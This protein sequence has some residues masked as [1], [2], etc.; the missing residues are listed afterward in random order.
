[1]AK[2]LDIQTANR[3]Y[4]F[5]REPEPDSDGTRLC[6]LYKG[7]EVIDGEDITKNAVFLTRPNPQTA[8]P[9]ARV[10][11]ENRMAA[12]DELK[13][14]GEV[15]DGL[16]TV[17]WQGTIETHGGVGIISEGVGDYDLSDVVKLAV[18]ERGEERTIRARELLPVQ[19]AVGIY[20][21][22]LDIVQKINSEKTD[23]KGQIVRKGII[24]CDIIPQNIRL[25]SDLTK[26]Y[27]IDFGIAREHGGQLTGFFN[28]TPYIEEYC[29][30]EVEVDDG[31][32]NRVRKQA[33]Y[34]GS[35]N[36]FFNEDYRPNGIEKVENAHEGIDV[37][38]TTNILYLM[39]MGKVYKGTIELPAD[40]PNRDVFE[41]VFAAG[42]NLQPTFI[43][44]YKEVKDALGVLKERIASASE[45]H[46]LYERKIALR[47]RPVGMGMEYATL[48]DVIIEAKAASEQ[49]ILA[50]AW[51][52]YLAR[53]EQEYAA[54]EPVWEEII[55]QYKEEAGDG[56]KQLEIRSG[57]RSL[58]GKYEEQMRMLKEGQTLVQGKTPLE[59]RIDKRIGQIEKLNQ[60]YF[61][62]EAVCVAEEGKLEK[63]NHDLV[64]QIRKGAHEAHR[65][66]EAYNNPPPLVSIAA[67]QTA[68]R[69]GEDAKRQ[70]DHF[71]EGYDAYVAKLKDK[72]QEVGSED[73]E[74]REALASRLERLIKKAENM[75]TAVN[76]CF[77]K[78]LPHEEQRKAIEETNDTFKRGIE[79]CSAVQQVGWEFAEFEEGYS[80][81]TKGLYQ[82]AERLESEIRKAWKLVLHAESLVRMNPDRTAVQVLGAAADNLEN[83]KKVLV[84]FNQEYNAHRQKLADQQV[85]VL[86]KGEAGEY[87][88]PQIDELQK[89]VHGIEEKVGYVP[90]L[91]L[92]DQIGIITKTYTRL[93]REKR[94]YELELEK[95]EQEQLFEE[96]ITRKKLIADAATAQKKLVGRYKT[97]RKEFRD[98][99]YHTD[100]LPQEVKRVVDAA[101]ERTRKFREA[102]D[103]TIANLEAHIGHAEELSVLVREKPFGDYDA[104]KVGDVVKGRP[105]YVNFLAR[106]DAFKQDVSKESDPNARYY[107]AVAQGMILLG[108]DWLEEAAQKQRGIRYAILRRIHRSEDQQPKRE[109]H[110]R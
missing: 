87:V 48:R 46:H 72:T 86:G 95:K 28:G 25:S 31:A 11:V 17:V 80:P 33:R 5:S 110:D 75:R 3:T 66:N 7:W 94:Y 4:R 15:I 78:E 29:I 27:L 83:T 6:Y 32:G 24:H 22:I 67:L 9:L 98:T 12:A 64:Q 73:P 23:E 106:V 84:A 36:L 60:F 38:M 30:P 70:Y 81:R 69:E 90:G 21:K 74:I 49:D 92:E 62:F 105:V 52:A 91:L 35:D 37:Y 103:Q 93:A 45:E 39:I 42:F 97:V 101:Q 51:E 107:Q 56:L 8:G 1:M 96:A 102:I 89:E 85:L 88:M 19:T 55:K 41:K 71:F 26:V 53:A 59:E 16:P 79:Q 40:Y 63:E 68:V 50:R 57:L 109:H 10:F 65:A 13:K 44:G 108:E 104:K 47:K 58:K 54:K 82:E 100:G 43:K 34:G 77:E 61:S 99:E 76:G 20:E 14:E 2:K 18:D